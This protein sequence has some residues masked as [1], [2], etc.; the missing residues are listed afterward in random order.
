MFMLRVQLEQCGTQLAQLG[1]RGGP[2][3]DLGAALASRIND[4]AQYHVIAVAFCLR[5]QPFACSGIGREIKLCGDVGL[6][7][8]AAHHRT[9]CTGAERQAERIKHD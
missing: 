4:P 2:T 3:V 5:R 8:T 9:L 1:H 6:L 7:F